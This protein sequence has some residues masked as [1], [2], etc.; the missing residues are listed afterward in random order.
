[1][2]YQANTLRVKE[3]QNGIAELCFS[4]P[5]SVNKLDLATLESLDAALDAIKQTQNIDGLMLTSDKDS[6]IVGADITEFLGLFAKPD[7]ELDQWLQ[8]A[9]QIF[10][11]LEDLPF[12]TISVL[13]GHALGG[14][15]ECVLATDFRIGDKT[16]S[17]GLPETKL[18]IIARSLVVACR[19][20]RVSWG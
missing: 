11:K 19:L 6:F 20:P 8:F 12:P 5:N 7:A 15:C 3:V 14:G 10:S 9:N 17:I 1:M 4:S 2:I 13:K 16:T 18:G